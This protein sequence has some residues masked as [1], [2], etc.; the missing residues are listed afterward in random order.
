[1]GRKI[2]LYIYA[3]VETK[4]GH[5]RSSASSTP[6]SGSSTSLGSLVSPT[7]SL[8]SSASLGSLASSIPLSRSSASLTP[9]SGSSALLGSLASP[10]PSLG[11]SASPIP[12]SYSVSFPFMTS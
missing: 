9:S 10:T 1:M 6:S 3:N 8:G 11:S 7:L 5:V 12:F 4:Q 2:F